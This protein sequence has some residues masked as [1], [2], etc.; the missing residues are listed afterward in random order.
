M[1]RPRIQ[2]DLVAV[3]RSARV[4]TLDD[5]GRR[6]CV[7]RRTVLRRLR[8]HGCFS[9]YNHCGWYLTIGEVAGFDSRGLFAC[10]VAR[11]SRHG[12]L[13]ETLKHFVDASTSGMTHEELCELLGV[14]VH[15]PL[16][17]LTTEG[18]I[19]RLRHGP[20]FVYVSAASEVQEAQIRARS[21]AFGDVAPRPTSRQVIAV[22]LEL[23]RD[24]KASREEIVSRCQ[25][26]G[27]R[28]TRE[29]LDAIFTRYDLDKKRAL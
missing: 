21:L 3:F 23:I 16:L 15:N 4:L 8:E 17:D 25:R 10:G 7:S 1:A 13:K 27:V 26:S 14:R 11:F 18:A 9:S 2:T 24:P 22:L 20:V 19:A 6:L 28:I 12:A 29:T 5:L